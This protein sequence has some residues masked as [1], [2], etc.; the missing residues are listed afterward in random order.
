[1]TVT[2]R[3]QGKVHYWLL[4]KIYQLQF[5][6]TNVRNFAEDA[7]ITQTANNFNFKDPNL[8]FGFNATFVLHT[9][10]KKLK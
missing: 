4:K 6:L 1:M 5:H 10:K 9:K 3:C 7:F 2:V 8:H